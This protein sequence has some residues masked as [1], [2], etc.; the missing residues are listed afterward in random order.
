MARF[1]GKVAL[2]TGGGS[3]IGRATAL[4]LAAEGAV[5]AVVDMSADAAGAVASEIAAGGGSAQAV[6]ADVGLP[7]D[8]ARAVAQTQAAFGPVRV[9]VNAAATFL[10]RG[11]EAT[12]EDWDRAL[13][14]NVRASALLVAAAA[15]GMRQA[16][17]G[18]VVNIAS[19]SAYI[20][21][22]GRW[23]YNTTK[24]AVL[25]L[26]RAQAWDLARHGIRVN[27][28]S[29]GTIWTPQVDREAGGDRAH[30]E[31]IWGQ[32][33][34]LGRCG[35]P[36]E[37]ARAILFLCSDDA[38]FIT[39]TDLRVDGGYLSMSHDSPGEGDRFR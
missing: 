35:E 39:G 26:T 11:A 14:V 24:G 31:P 34:M 3:G 13:A 12:P 29:P 4:E 9:L 6:T 37:V 16:G 23:T 30:W 38:S 33:H 21:Q 36:R 27:S 15:E 32:R 10:S 25:S 18:A 17:G 7:A 22:P 20:A 28:V 19:I 5:V 8:C 2:V 1:K